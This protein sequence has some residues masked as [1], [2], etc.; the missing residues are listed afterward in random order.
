[1][2]DF[3][4]TRTALRHLLVP[5][6]ALGTSLVSYG[7]L[8][9]ASGFEFSFAVMTTVLVYA[10]PGQLVFIEVLLSG[11][12]AGPVPAMVA[13]A[14]SSS[15]L[16]ILTALSSPWF[17]AVSGWRWWRY[18]IA[19]LMAVTSWMTLAAHVDAVPPAARIRYFLIVGTGLWL[20]SGSC[21][22]LG[23]IL[24]DFLSPAMLASFLIFNPCYFAILTVSASLKETRI[25]APVCVGA[26]FA[27]LFQDLSADLVLPLAGLVGGSVS[28]FAFLAVDRRAARR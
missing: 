10:L 16:T 2:A 19:H 26:L 21:T 12:G 22:A 6:C 13:V 9:A 17:S 23:Y 5:A 1:M 27:L 8:L 25:A 15:R 14:A 11:A 18:Y 24:A 20:T 7:A 3:A 4:V 28:F